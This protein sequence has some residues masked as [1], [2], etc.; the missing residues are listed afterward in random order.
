MGVR[1]LNTFEDLGPVTNLNPNPNPVITS[2]LMTGMVTDSLKEANS[3]NRT[4]LKN[5]SLKTTV[6]TDCHLVSDLPFLGR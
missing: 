3:G 5:P 1:D 6:F 4:T 2:P